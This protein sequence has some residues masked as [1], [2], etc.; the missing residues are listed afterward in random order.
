MK[1]KYKWMSLFTLV[2]LMLGMVTAQNTAQNADERSISV[3]GSGT[4][5]GEPDVAL[6]ELGVDIT[7]EDLNAASSEA[8]ETM[9][10][11]RDALLAAGVDAKDIRTLTFNIWRE[12][13]YAYD[14]SPRSEPATPLYHVTNVVQV[15]VREVGRAGEVLSSA[16]DAGANVVNGVQYTFS[17]AD[18]LERQAREL[19]FADAQSKAEQ[20]AS[21]AGATLGPAVSISESGSGGDPFYNRGVMATADSMGEAPVSGGQLAV[22]VTVSASFLLYGQEQ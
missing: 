10:R 3:S 22:T 14:S 19:A 7:N 12:Q 20:L 18:A 2:L 21:L 8:N 4:V 6:L 11:V 17:D 15:T 5:Y 1:T 16:V 13:P 9:Q